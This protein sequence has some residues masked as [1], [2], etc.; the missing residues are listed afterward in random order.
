MILKNNLIILV[1]LQTCLVS[2]SLLGNFKLKTQ[3]KRVIASALSKTNSASSKLFRP[4]SLFSRDTVPVEL[5]DNT[6]AFM[7]TVDV[8]S[9]NAS[10]D[11]IIDSGSADLWIPSDLFC[12]K[13]S[14][15]TND[16]YNP[17]ASTTAN[18]TG[19]NYSIDYVGSKGYTG[20]IYN[21]T[22]NVAGFELK[23]AQFASVNDGETPQP[24]AGIG[25]PGLNNK[26]PYYKNLPQQMKEQD[27]I[28]NFGY[29]IYLDSL[30]SSDGLIVFG[31]VFT[32]GYTGKYKQL[33]ILDTSSVSSV[34]SSLYIDFGGANDTEDAWVL[35]TP[36]RAL[37][38][39]GST[40]LILPTDMHK[41]V[42]EI[43]DIQPSDDGDV[44][45]CS[46][47][48]QN[49]A[50]FK[51]NFL[52]VDID[53]PF[54]VISYPTNDT[55]CHAAVSAIDGDYV[56]LGEFFLRATTL[57]FDLENQLISIAQAKL[58][59]DHDALIDSVAEV[60]SGGV[61]FEK[62]PHFEK[63]QV[64]SA[65]K[66][67]SITPYSTATGGG[68]GGFPF[69]FNFAKEANT[70]SSS[71]EAKETG[72][73]VGGIDISKIGGFIPDLGV[74]LHKR[75][76]SGADTTFSSVMS[77]SSDAVSHDISSYEA[78]ASSSKG[79][80]IISIVMVLLSAVCLL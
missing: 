13:E 12:E 63:T 27:F 75:N 49:E 47:Y 4:S 60:P 61:Y 72:N 19:Y 42:L 62:A 66:G 70:S 41:K 68:G 39:T 65:P 55:H 46:K 30:N 50:A 1:L 58:N 34:L 69:S 31:G 37:F 45:D 5:K 40:A 2:A 7:I 77:T 76:D 21:D 22:V 64:S 24:I 9:Q 56:I 38:D 44:F 59:Q 51:F 26:P 14:G 18:A 54:N 80:G 17:N 35:Q 52:G 16:G 71:V 10:F 79:S 32:E 23:N 43:L 6:N 36:I 57:Y 33:P 73:P 48:D 20:Q 78:G 53:V 25:Y 28:D 8:G 11:C 15:C 3:S 67:T 29:G 74:G